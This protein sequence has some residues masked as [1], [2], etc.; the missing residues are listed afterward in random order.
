VDS[1]LAGI[2]IEKRRLLAATLGLFAVLFVAVGVVATT[3]TTPGVVRV[4][5]AVALIVAMLLGAVAWGVT[6]SV[7]TDLREQRLDRAIERAIAEGAKAH[8]LTCDCGHDHD[9]DEMHVTD[10]DDR[11]PVSGTDC[12][13]SCDS[14]VLAEMRP[15]PTRSRAQRLSQ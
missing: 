12:A 11:C 1:R 15:S 14:C 5:S 3:G 9:M 2:P 7:T 10:A 8:A 6:H 4:F 13:H